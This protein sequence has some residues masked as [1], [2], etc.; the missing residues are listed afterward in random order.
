MKMSIEAHLTNQAA[1]AR[2]FI[3]YK[4]A[5][6]DQT[7]ARQLAAALE[8]HCDVF[9][10]QHI[11]AGTNWARQITAEL[12]RADF[13]VVL[14]SKLSVESEMVTAEIELARDLAAERGVKRPQILPVRVMY[15]ERLPLPLNGYFRLVHWIDWEKPDDTPCVLAALLRAMAL[16]PVTAAVPVV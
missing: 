14:L 4:H 9:I 12:E 11:V 13:F 8:Q 1:R 15:R 7:L 3:S 6:P 16:Q 10:D 2:V 5:E